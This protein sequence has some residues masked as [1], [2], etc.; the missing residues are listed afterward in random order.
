M[1]KI[2]ILMVVILLISS[3]SAF[4]LDDFLDLELGVITGKSVDNREPSV[5]LSRPVDTQVVNNPVV[6]KWRYFDAEDDE[7]EFYILQIDDDRR[8]FSPENFK[9]VGT[10][11]KVVL[12]EGLYYWRVKVV[13]E[14]GEKF[15]EVWEFYVDPKMKVC[16]DGS[17]Y[18]ECSVNKPFY[19]SAGR[20]KDDCQRCGCDIGS[21]C[22]PD[23]S[24]LVLNC[25]DG[26]KYGECA[27]E[28][29]VYCLD[30]SL[31]E[32]C[33]IC[34]CDDGFECGGDGSCEEIEG[35]EI[36]PVIRPPVRELSFLERIAQFFKRLFLGS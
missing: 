17:P 9:G 19:C 4:S 21:V 22:Q 26:T 29:P 28:K 16:G 1:K 3:V 7:M 36:E 13:N 33:N 34:G 18:F 12:D 35:G 8:F 14:F 24:C 5:T 2:L 32:L 15:S 6:F 25:V 23:G 11:A 10:E 31:R 27:L 30:G 20:L